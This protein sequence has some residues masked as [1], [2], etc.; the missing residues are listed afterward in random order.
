MELKEL[1]FSYVEKI[2]NSEKKLFENF[3]LRI[4][5]EEIT[6]LLGASGCGKSTLLRIF[7]GLL[8][9]PHENQAVIKSDLTESFVFQEPSLLE[10]KTGLQNIM[11]PLK[12]SKSELNRNHFDQ[13]VETLRI[14]S[15]L[16]R[17]PHQLSGGQKMRVSVARALV[18]R[19]NII[20]MDE[21]FSALDEPTR[22]QLQDDLRLWQRQFK[23]TVLFVTHSFYEAVSIADRIVV[24]SQEKPVRI[25][26]DESNLKTFSSRFESAYQDKVFEISE[27]FKRATPNA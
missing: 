18:T 6:C 27:V 15:L 11:L 26:Y 23:M 19:P 3:N 10:W 22:L 13:I 16:D 24:L 14:S 25:V 4:K 7:A 2:Q 12:I 5:L 21:P 17:F 9:A 20:Y 8:K 1:H